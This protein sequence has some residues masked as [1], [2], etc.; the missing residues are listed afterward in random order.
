MCAGVRLKEAGTVV[1]W[2]EE[3]VSPAVVV[4]P[5]IVWKF[6]GAIDRVI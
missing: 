1:G 4:L 2:G 5:F 6:K 3:M